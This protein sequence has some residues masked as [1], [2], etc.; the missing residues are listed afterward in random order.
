MG[1]REPEAVGVAVEP[2]HH[3]VARFEAGPIVEQAEQG[4]AV[5]D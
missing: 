1:G 2:S 5:L 3:V 4:R